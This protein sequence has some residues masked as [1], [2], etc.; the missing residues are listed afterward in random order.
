MY[1]EILLLDESESK[2]LPAFVTPAATQGALGGE[3][4]RR[5]KIDSDRSPNEQFLS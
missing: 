4:M 1:G 5:A 3:I 2:I